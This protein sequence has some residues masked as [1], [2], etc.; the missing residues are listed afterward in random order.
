LQALHLLDRFI[1]TNP[2]KRPSAEV[3]LLHPF[4]DNAET[5]EDYSTIPSPDNLVDPNQL[6]DFEVKGK[7]SL[8]E[9]KRKIAEECE[10]YRLLNKL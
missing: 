9:M 8:E 7:Y 3:A 2:T 5:V 1:Q 10:Y 4:L 6:F